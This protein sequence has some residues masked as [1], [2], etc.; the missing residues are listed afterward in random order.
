[1][2]SKSWPDVL[3]ELV[4]QTPLILIA[5]VAMVAPQLFNASNLDISEAINAGEG[6]GLV[7][8]GVA[9]KVLYSR[10]RG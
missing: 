6:T 3:S 9:A 7:I 2:P 4:K 8:G 5:I 10:Y 1:M